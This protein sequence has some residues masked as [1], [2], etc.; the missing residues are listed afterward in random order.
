MRERA[1]AFGGIALI[2]ASVLF[3]E[4]ALTRFFSFRLWYHYA[5]M[6]IS[7]ALL[8]LSGAATAMALLRERLA[9]LGAPRVLAAGALLYAVALG[10]TPAV[11]A[12]VGDLFLQTPS[13]T[14]LQGFAL[15]AS[16][17]GVLFVPFFL[18]GCVISWAIE[19]FAS[20]MGAAYGAD[21]AGAGLGA[22][23]AAWLLFHVHPEAALPLAGSAAVLAA[24]LFHA[25]HGPPRAGMLAAAGAAL[26]V[27]VGVNRIDVPNAVRVTPSKGLAQ[28]LR[29][30]G[31]IVASRP[32]PAGR[33]DVVAL[34]GFRHAW[35][36]SAESADE[37]PEQ[38]AVR[39]DGDAL[40]AVTR[41]DGDLGAWR[42]ADA[43]PSSLPFALRAPDSV[44]VIGAGGG[45]DVGNALARGARHVIGVEVNGAVIDLVRGPFAAFAGDL[46][47]HP[48]V[49]IVH[50]D[51]RNFIE[52]TKARYDLIQLTLVDTFAAISS[53]ALS[54]SEDFLY[55]TE[56]F[57]AY[58]GALSPDGMLALGRTVHEALPLAALVDA[59][60]RDGAVDLGRHLFV[61]DD[62]EILHSLIFVFSSSPLTPDEIA[63]GRSFVHR[64]GL[65]LRYAPGAE[66]ES[67]PELAAFLS[68]RDRDEFLAGFHRDVLPETDDRPF[69]FRAS[70]WSD[71][72]G[73]YTGGRGNLWIVL[74]VAVLFAAGLIVAPLAL[75]AGGTARS[76]AGL[77]GY[78][79]LI[80]LGFILLELGLL[81]KLVL[82]LGHPVRSLTVSLFALLLF[83]GVGSAISRAL[84]RRS[85]GAGLRLLVLPLFGVAIL[86]TG[87]GVL[88]PHWLSAWM[89]LDLTVR[90]AVAT[91]FI[92]PL[93]LLLGMPLP[94]GMALVASRERALVLWAWGANGAASVIG[95][96]ACILLAHA[97]GYTSAFLAAAA[98]Y[99]LA[100]LFLV[101][102][103]ART[104]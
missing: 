69:Y 93:G 71:V 51:G 23:A 18:A 103:V 43:M 57:R 81:T 84:L 56:A 90:V 88:L 98:C 65:R 50:G 5:F 30:G 91:A 24:V 79:A 74:L 54:L 11:L 7:I 55:T 86:A 31:R 12:A 2:S 27:C 89:G 34:P 66:A 4:I 58:L 59:A 72:L 29:A 53:G 94:I 36:V 42:F 60:S 46:Y 8:G 61:A 28:D 32:S 3:S 63:R 22:A 26:L 38:L 70:K 80:G 44:V 20:R 102:S 13:I 41:L 14:R 85:T 67:D 10:V 35:G 92:A 17:W 97:A 78:F 77:L 9:R 6:I 99:L 73:T 64:A 76:H 15:I 82:F 101:R 37:F 52:G 83:S 1:M 25:A 16:C 45:M 75:T 100:S 21:L 68:A 39:I 47:R 104:A 62:P 48:R 87:Y 96:V 33:V 95:S 40:T 49:R 19:T